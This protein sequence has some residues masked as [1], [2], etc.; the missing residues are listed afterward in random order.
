M[1]MKI[2]RARFGRER[3]ELG[4]ARKPVN[5][6]NKVVVGVDPVRKGAKRVAGCSYKAMVEGSNTPV[7]AAVPCLELVASQELVDELQGCFVG[8]LRQHREAHTIKHSMVMEG[9]EGISVIAMGVRLV[10]LQ[11]PN[12]GVIVQA[13]AEHRLWWDGMFESSKPWTPNMVSKKRITWLKVVGIPVHVWEEEVFKKIGAIYGEF[14]DFAEETI[15]KTRV[16]LAFIKVVTERTGLIDEHMTVKVVGA[17]FGLWVVEVGG[18]ACFC[19]AAVDRRLEEGSNGESIEEEVVGTAFCESED[20][21]VAPEEAMRVGGEVDRLCEK[22]TSQ[23]KGHEEG[24]QNNFLPCQITC[25]ILG[26]EKGLTPMVEGHVDAGAEKAGGRDVLAASGSQLDEFAEGGGMQ[27]ERGAWC[28]KEGGVTCVQMLQAMERG[29]NIPGAHHP[30][31]SLT[32]FNYV[33]FNLFS[34]GPVGPSG[35]S[36]NVVQLCE[37]GGSSNGEAIKVNS[38]IRFT[39]DDSDISEFSDSV[40]DLVEKEERFLKQSHKSK[41]QRKQDKHPTNL[42]GSS[43]RRRSAADWRGQGG[44][45]LP[46]SG[47]EERLRDLNVVEDSSDEMLAEYS[48]SLPPSN[49]GLRLIMEEQLKE[50]EQERCVSDNVDFIKHLQD[51]KLFGIQIEVGFNF[52]LPNDSTKKAFVI[53]PSNFEV[54]GIGNGV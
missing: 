33:P 50:R 26:E 17:V 24:L 12:R 21:E 19:T 49:S 16:D 52:S 32:P 43:G 37:N 22:S 51:S 8:S 44:G 15:A 2:S 42:V 38:H 18:P 27:Q 28:V 34:N 23:V 36:R 20:G 29:R 13:M 46:C 5:G 54:N 45:F 11:A 9:L 7:P 4:V 14:L 30:G 48:S 41:L 10:L 31:F 25:P 35:S 1:K 3:Q 40:E 6:G 39:D 47:E 53:G